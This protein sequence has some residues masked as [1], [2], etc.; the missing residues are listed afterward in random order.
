MNTSDLIAIERF[1]AMLYW[2]HITKQRM[3]M[4]PA[5]RKQTPLPTWTEAGTKLRTIWR[6]NALE[7]IKE[8][9][10]SLIDILPQV[11][12]EASS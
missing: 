3:G 12:H 10:V 2:D 7:L 5:T 9:Q 6:K 4:A 8:S 11:A 1:A